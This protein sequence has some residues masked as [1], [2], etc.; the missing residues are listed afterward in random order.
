MVAAS[1]AAYFLWAR[2]PA[3][4]AIQTSVPAAPLD[5]P[6][7]IPPPVAP[8]V[9]AAQPR[10]FAVV[11]TASAGVFV[12]GDGEPRPARVADPLRTGDGLVTRGGDGRAAVLLAE[13]SR[14]DVSPDTVLARVTAP[15]PGESGGGRLFLTRGVVHS[16]RSP[17]SPASAGILRVDTPLGS[18]SLVSARVRDL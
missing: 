8:D 18:V 7:S 14:I 6:A 15:G 10:L 12:L 13:G 4:V 2:P 9:Q 16:V 1:T 17:A 11:T 5:D 3:P